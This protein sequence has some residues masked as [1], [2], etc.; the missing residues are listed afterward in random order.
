MPRE[1]LVAISKNLQ[2]TIFSA[3]PVFGK[4]ASYIALLTEQDDD[5]FQEVEATKWD[6]LHR[7]ILFC[8]GSHGSHRTK[9]TYVGSVLM[10]H[11]P[12]E[13]RNHRTFQVHLEDANGNSLGSFLASREPN[14]LGQYDVMACVRDFYDDHSERKGLQ[15]GVFKQLVEWLEW[16]LMLG[17]E[18]FLVYTFSGSDSMELEV[19]KPYLDAAVATM[20]QFDHHP[21]YPVTRQGHMMNDC[22][23]RAKNHARWLMPSVDVDEYL[24]FRGLKVGAA[25]KEGVLFQDL[26]NVNSLAFRRIRFARPDPHQLE[27]SSTRFERADLQSYRYLNPKQVVQV[28]LAYRL[29]VHQVVFSQGGHNC[30]VDP[31]T[32]FF[33]HYRFPYD[34]VSKHDN[35]SGFFDDLAILTDESLLPHVPLLVEAIRRRFNLK[36]AEDV[37]SFLQDLAR[38]L[39]RLG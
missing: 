21:P 10:C 28:A 16:S 18:H 11:W 1:Q 2:I 29:S 17:V 34:G 13:E 23:F 20:V 3:V 4:N 32:A 30:I 36:Q 35:G 24:D 37:H 27:I 19:L 25:L 6:E 15:L 9:I 14:L 8:S 33:H 31:K 12:P 7:Q 5:S 26:H 38:A 39:P 22:L